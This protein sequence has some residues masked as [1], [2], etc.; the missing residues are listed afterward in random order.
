MK[1]IRNAYP[2]FSQGKPQ[3]HK[4]RAGGAA[5]RELDKVKERTRKADC[6]H[7][8]KLPR[9]RTARLSHAEDY[10]TE[11][12]RALAP[13]CALVL[14][15]QF[16]SLVIP[17]QAGTHLPRSPTIATPHEYPAPEMG[18]RLRGNDEGGGWS[19]ASAPACTGA[20]EG[21]IT[22]TALPRLVPAA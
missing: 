18:S 3:M 13:S 10:P 15:A 21:H 8:G 9:C 16:S 4:S 14:P 6:A 22:P 1:H 19:A 17:A 11:G 7:C 12:F 20:L 2:E 5:G